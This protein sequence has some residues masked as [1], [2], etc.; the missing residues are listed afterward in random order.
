MGLS[1]KETHRL[2]DALPDGDA[3]AAK[4]FIE[5]LLMQSRLRGDLSGRQDLAPDQVAPM[6]ELSP[7]RVRQLIREGVITARR[8]GGRWLIRAEDLQE[9]LTPEAQVFLTHPLAKDDL[10]EEEK[11]ASEEGWREHLAGNTIP[12]GDLMREHKHETRKD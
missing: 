1:R 4:R 6:L 9:L 11:A 3:L 2:L 7:R 10:T 5:F 12:L 8:D